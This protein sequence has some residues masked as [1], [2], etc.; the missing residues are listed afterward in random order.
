MPIDIVVGGSE[1]PSWI[2][3]SADLYRTLE[4]QGVTCHYHERPGLNHFSIL[5]DLRGPGDY[6]AQL[7]KQ[8]LAHA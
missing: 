1:T 4:E 8:G 7:V 6:T 2:A 5:M 3:Q